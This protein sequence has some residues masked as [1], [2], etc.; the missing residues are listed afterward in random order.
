ME[1]YDNDRVDLRKDNV[2]NT[3][4][5]E[6]FNPYFLVGPQGP[7]GI[8]GRP[9][10]RGPMGATGPTGPAATID[11]ILVDY[12]GI[13]T[14]SAGSLINLGTVINSTGTSL[15]F[16]VPDTVNLV[17]AGT[18]FIQFSALVANTSA[19]GDV[20]ASML[21]N[22]A[23]AHNASEYILPSS[24]DIKIFLQHSVT[25]TAMKTVQIRNYSTVSNNYHDTSLSVL[26]LA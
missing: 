23:I 22:G 8:Q 17:E 10:A 15:T 9:G 19:S 24:V 3:R 26:K 12:D 14:V 11:S 16:S 18:Y 1:E 13:Q 6:C 20:G 5:G 4:Y 25:I 21:I 7:Q 2:D